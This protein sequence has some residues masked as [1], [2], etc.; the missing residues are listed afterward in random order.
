VESFP[1]Y[2]SLLSFPRSRAALFG[3]YGFPQFYP[4]FP[5]SAVVSGVQERQLHLLF[6]GQILPFLSRL[7]V[8]YSAQVDRGFVLMYLVIPGGSSP[9]FPL[10]RADPR[11]SS[12]LRSPLV[13][14]SFPCAA[15]NAEVLGY[16]TFFFPFRQLLSHEHSERMLTVSGPVFPPSGCGISTLLPDL[17]YFLHFVTPADLLFSSAVPFLSLPFSLSQRFVSSRDFAFVK[18]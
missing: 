8:S 1:Y 11:E 12:G 3:S 14:A 2:V 13:R 6:P 10:C 4:F 7:E 15:S 9:P 16:V 5:A 18:S 17:I